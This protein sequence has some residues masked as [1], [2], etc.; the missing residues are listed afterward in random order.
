MHFEQSVRSRYQ[1]QPEE[2]HVAGLFFLDMRVS[3][4]VANLNKFQK[5]WAIQIPYADAKANALVT[6]Y[7][8]APSRSSGTLSGEG[9]GPII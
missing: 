7:A 6:E 2:D 8:A 5:E 9:L 3:K 1:I 4:R